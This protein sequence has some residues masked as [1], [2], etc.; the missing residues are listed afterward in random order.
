MGK[1]ETYGT[2]LCLLLWWEKTQKPSRKLNARSG[3]G[4]LTSDR[5]KVTLNDPS[6]LPYL[7][8]QQRPSGPGRGQAHSHYTRLLLALCLQ[9]LGISWLPWRTALLT[10][11]C[12]TSPLA[13]A[14]DLC[15]WTLDDFLLCQHNAQLVTGAN[16]YES[17]LYQISG[18]FTLC[19]WSLLRHL[20]P[21]LCCPLVIAGGSAR[22]WL[23]SEGLF[24]DQNGCGCK[25]PALCHLTCLLPYCFVSSII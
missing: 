15:L 6:K 12:A 3:K 20:F 14:S 17:R 25:I 18:S 9:S 1:P 10:G 4:P 16:K 13:L 22:L 5:C 19:I 2:W 11:L 21:G 24:W 23:P 7:T 8:P